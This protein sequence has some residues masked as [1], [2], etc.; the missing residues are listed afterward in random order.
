M[1]DRLV[2]DDVT[3]DIPIYDVKSRSLKHRVLLNQVSSLMPRAEPS[4][5]GSV[6]QDHRGIVIV[7]ALDRIS[8]AA[9]D[10]DRIAL[11]GHNG[12]GKTTLLRVAA[13]IFEPTSG[14]VQ[15]RGRV[16]PLLNIME[17]MT[18]E[19][20]GLEMIRLRGTLLGLSEQE[21]EDRVEE[22]TQF[23]DLGQYINMPV[24]TYSTGMQVRLAFAVTTAVESDVLIMDEVIGAGD[25]AFFERAEA[26]LKAFV[27]RSSLLLFATHSPELV[28]KW[29]NRAML[30]Q[31]GRMVEYGDAETVLA[32]Y[33]RSTAH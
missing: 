10:G 6:I 7:R 15:T 26:R 32:A 24:R 2:F 4:I 16:L 30:L 5:G 25:A 27:E 18:P 23:C 33:A 11:I 20:T 29:C 31:H 14:T 28:R 12:A 3:V 8:F 1:Q 22:I 13:G 19:S 9:A 17:G 21:I